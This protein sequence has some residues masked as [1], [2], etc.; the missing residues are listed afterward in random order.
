MSPARVRALAAVVTV[1]LFAWSLDARATAILYATDA[2]GPDG[3]PAPATSTL[4]TVN[5]SSGATT[6]VGPVGYL[7][8]GMDWYGGTLYGVTSRHDPA[9]HGLIEIDVSTGAGTPI[10]SGWGA[11]IGL[12]VAEMAIDS[13]GNAFGWNI[14]SSNAL[15]RINLD[16]GDGVAIGDAGLLGFSLGLAFDL[17]DQLFLIDRSSE[18]YDINTVTGAPTFLGRLSR[19][20]H[21]DVNPDGG[22]YYG[23]GN[24]PGEDLPEELVVA[25]LST[26]SVLSRVTADRDLHTLAFVPEPRIAALLALGLAGFALSRAARALDAASPRSLPAPGAS[27]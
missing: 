1:G 5:P 11:G 17:S 20:R 16:T 8:T 7:V 4:F 22:L 15:Y 27:S 2:H 14:A 26:L 21:G 9:F 18:V 6:A 25:N 19:A 24:N 10:G 23:L 13:S 12:T 3:L